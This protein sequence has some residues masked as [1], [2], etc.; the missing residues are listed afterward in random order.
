MTEVNAGSGVKHISFLLG[1]HQLF[2][3]TIIAFKR[4]AIMSLQ[5]LT[6][7]SRGE[8]IGSRLSGEDGLDA[9]KS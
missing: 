9:N 1:N 3:F 7:E 8:I 2:F 4:V 5:T 6:R